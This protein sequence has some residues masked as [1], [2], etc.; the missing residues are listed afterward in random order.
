[1]SVSLFGILVLASDA[2]RSRTWRYRLE[3]HDQ[4]PNRDVAWKGRPNIIPK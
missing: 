3:S 2:V 4:Y 1:M